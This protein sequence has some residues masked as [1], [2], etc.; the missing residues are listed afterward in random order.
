MEELRIPGMVYDECFDPRATGVPKE[1]GWPEPT[2]VVRR[3][4]GHQLVYDVDRATAL[5]M[6]EHAI[7]WGDT[8][9][10]GVDPDMARVAKRVAQ[11]GR[12]ERERIMRMGAGMGV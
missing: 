9:S 3:G 2:R 5:D 11:W 8:L 12:H 10:F 6:A 4:F 1:N 7:E